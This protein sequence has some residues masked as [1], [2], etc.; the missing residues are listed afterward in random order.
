M[1]KVGFLKKYDQIKL[2]KENLIFRFSGMEEPCNDLTDLLKAW[3]CFPEKQIRPLVINLWGSTGVGKT[4][5]I[6]ELI[7]FLNLKDYYFEY[8]CSQLRL[9]KIV[10]TMY[11]LSKIQDK[12]R[13]VFFLDNAHLLIGQNLENPFDLSITK[14]LIWKMIGDGFLEIKNSGVQAKKIRE[15]HQEYMYW[16]QNGLKVN[17]GMITSKNPRYFENRGI[18]IM[19]SKPTYVNDNLIEEELQQF[20]FS[21]YEAKILFNSR[22][23]DFPSYREFLDGIKTMDEVQIMGFLDDILMKAL[24]PERVD[25][26]QSVFIISGTLNEMFSK[27]KEPCGEALTAQHI[28][29]VLQQ[30]LGVE[31]VGRLGVN[32][33]L[34]PELS[35][36]S[37]Q[38]MIRRELEE[39]SNQF[40]SDNGV[41]LQFDDELLDFILEEKIDYSMGGWSLISIID[42]LIK[43]KIPDWV[44]KSQ[45]TPLVNRIGVYV[46]NHNIKLRIE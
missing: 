27:E 29:N 26:S 28:K 1:E 3:Y 18:P 8:D 21:R 41:T 4:S 11:T 17:Q 19:N 37:F 43:N 7:G 25:V 34:F 40:Y 36:K 9:P 20:V 10:D 2:A 31:L 39:I 16:F 38:Q 30:K 5:M 24:S 45:E 13:A 46:E 35:K 32:Y 44:K 22:L 15:I 6:K 33:I 12:I 14:N 23:H 42:G